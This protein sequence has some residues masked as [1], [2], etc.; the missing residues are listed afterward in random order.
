MVD[1][2]KNGNGVNCLDIGINE[3]KKY[4]IPSNK[5]VY[6]DGFYEGEIINNQKHG[7]GIF[8][9]NNGNKMREGK[10]KN[11]VPVGKWTTYKE[12]GSIQKIMDH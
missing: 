3:A 7:Q 12:D 1:K 2:V 6:D 10:L 11:G 8:W 9:Y 5:V 4:G